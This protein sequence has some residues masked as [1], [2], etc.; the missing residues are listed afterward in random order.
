MQ[1]TVLGRTGLEVS[2]A[3]L[4]CGGHSRLGMANGKDESHATRIVKHALDLGINFI[5]TARAYR[6]EVAV[7]HAIK[8]RRDQVV[9]STKSLVGRGNELL[10][11]EDI[12]SSLDKSLE[13]L[14]T[15]FI[16]IFN[17]HGVTA[18][19]YPHCIDEILPALVKQQEAGKIR[20]LGITET[21]I[22]DPSHKMLQ[23]ALNDDYFDVVM[24]GFNLLNPSARL[25]VFPLTIKNNVATQIMFAVRR[26]L[27][28]PDA[29][30]EVI[31]KLIAAGD[32]EESL[33]DMNSPL[34]FLEKNSEVRSIVQAAYRFCRYEPGA[35]VVLTGTGSEDHLRDNV[36]SILA[37]PLPA[38]L[39]AELSN[40]FGK[41]DSISGN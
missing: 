37:E 31:E 41:V 3:G 22:V 5:D 24:V 2:V 20:Y 14:Q 10:S 21:F 29:L 36:E 11:G 38:D 35:T 12:V 27:S 7:G 32:I 33:I 6:T 19:Q 4:G 30:L 17:L 26:A 9:V 23:L 39:T 40:L 15:D 34:G 16:D 13:N 1:T 18:E 25:S 28:Q 8:G